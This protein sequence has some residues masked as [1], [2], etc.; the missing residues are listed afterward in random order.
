M[1]EYERSNKAGHD[2]LTEPQRAEA[3]AAERDRII[4]DGKAAFRIAYEYWQSML[5]V[6]NTVEYFTL[7][8]AKGNELYMQHRDNAL[9]KDLILAVFG[10][11]GEQ[12]QNKSKG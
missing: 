10:W 7:A 12:G 4:K 9:A 8:G 5:P 6:E 11:L 2:L 1:T 3:K